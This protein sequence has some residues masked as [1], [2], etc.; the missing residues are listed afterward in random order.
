MST[1]GILVAC[2]DAAK[3]RSSYLPALAAAGWEGPCT[4]LT[5]GDPLPDLDDVAGLLLAGGLDIHP[6]AWDPAEPPHPQ[7]EPDEARD[8]LEIPLVRALWALH[9]PILGIC[10]GEQVLNVAL[11]GTLIQDIPDRCHC[12][13]DRHQHGNSAAPDL[14]HEVRLDPTSR[15]ATLLSAT[16]VPVNSRHHQAV[17]LVAPGLQAVGWHPDTLVPDSGPLIEAVEAADTGRWT[18]GVQWHPENL[19][20]LPG[21][22]GRCARA[23]FRAFRDAA[24][25]RT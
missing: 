25:L 3:V 8:A 16:V 2:R 11:G 15:L 12:P 7:A 13:A 1:T 24:A 6:R 4:V 9:R 10:R 14:R 22:A 21:E 20:D 5:P 19:M 17:D 18:F 23:L